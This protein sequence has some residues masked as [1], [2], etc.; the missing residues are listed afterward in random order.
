VVVEYGEIDLVCASGS[1]RGFK[2]GD[3]LWLVGLPLR[4]LENR[5]REAVLISAVS[6]SPAEPLPS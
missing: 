5:T 3:V 6:R 4:A 2:R 1:R